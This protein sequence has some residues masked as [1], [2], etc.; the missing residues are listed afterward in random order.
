MSNEERAGV[1]QGTLDLMILQTLA[2]IGPQLYNVKAV[3]PVA[4]AGA[5]AGCWGGRCSRAS[6]RPGRRCAAIRPVRCAKT[7]VRERWA[8]PAGAGCSR[9]KSG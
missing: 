3:D 6:A 1:L 8:N 2:S 7:E 4:V 9:S 5:P